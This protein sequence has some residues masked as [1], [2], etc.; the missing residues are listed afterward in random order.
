M[1]K[2]KFLIV[3]IMFIVLVCGCNSE[4]DRND[5]ASSVSSTNET[6]LWVENEGRFVTLDLARAQQEIPF[7]ILLP[8]YLPSD[9]QKKIPDIEGPLKQY[10]EDKVEIKIMFSLYPT[11]GMSGIIVIYESNSPASLADPELNPELET[12]DIKDI[13]VIK[14]RDDWSPDKDAYYSFEYAGIYY[15]MEMHGLSTGES[16]KIVESI[17]AQLK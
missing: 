11:R 1:K 9:S 12:V 7:A 17:L 14:T 13:T 4:T 2:T 8:K 3:L 16:K 10:Q 15:V 6:L 5:S